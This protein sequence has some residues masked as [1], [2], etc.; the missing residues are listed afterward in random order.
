MKVHFAGL[1]HQKFATI[2][3]RVAGIKYGLFTVFPFVAPGFDVEKTRYMSTD[4]A[5]CNYLTEKYQHVIMDSGLFT[6]MFGARAGK[7]SR[8][9]IYNWN[10]AIIRY[11]KKYGYSGAVVECDCQK[12]LG[13]EDAWTLRKKLKDSLPNEQINVWHNEDGKEGLDKMID[14]SNYIAISVPEWRVLAGGNTLP[15]RIFKIARYIKTKKPSIKIHLLGCTQNNIMR[16]CSF[17]DSCDSTSWQ[18]INRFGQG[19]VL[20][21][22]R[23][24]KTTRR[25]VEGKTSHLCQEI[26]DAFLLDGVQAEKA[27]QYFANYAAIAMYLK[28]E[29]A[30][31]AGGQE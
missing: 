5:V 14:F 15:D 2:L 22:N 11:V 3:S 28:Y 20:I 31:Y 27:R 17:C 21:D 8:P 23:F 7:R 16:Q 6:L 19:K 18:Q 1:E 12:V 26:N 24:V 9:F 10:D 4:F 30:R 29:Y 25:E 13:V